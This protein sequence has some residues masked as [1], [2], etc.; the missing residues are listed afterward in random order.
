MRHAGERLAGLDVHP[1]AVIIARCNFVLALAPDLPVKAPVNV[2]IYQDLIAVPVAGM[3][4][5]FHL[6]ADLAQD[7]KQMDEAIE[8]LGEM[9]RA[10]LLCRLKE[11]G[12]GN[13]ASVFEGNLRLL[14]HLVQTKRDTVYTFILRN[15]YRPELFA[16]RRFDL[17]A[18]NPPWLSY[19]DIGDAPT[20]SG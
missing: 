13:Y 11:L 12:L 15:A 2:P 19:R 14:R 1:L 10:G 16:R 5:A 8:A 3:R 18:G 4:R 9:A 6:P 7:P 20:S 17:V